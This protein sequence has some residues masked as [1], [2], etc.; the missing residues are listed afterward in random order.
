MKLYRIEGGVLRFGPGQKLSLDAA[1]AKR[2]EHNLTIEG[3]AGDRILVASM[4]PVE[5]KVGEVI[6]MPDLPKAFVDQVVPVGKPETEAEQV[7]VEKAAA[8]ADKK[9]V[10]PAKAMKAAA[11]KK[12]RAKAKK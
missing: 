2:R 1:Q 5:F 3:K 11:K 12:P 10:E 6:G 8:R 9:T 7:A 4:A